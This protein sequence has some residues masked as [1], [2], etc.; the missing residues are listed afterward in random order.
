MQLTRLVDGRSLNSVGLSLGALR[1]SRHFPH[2]SP[3]SLG[4]L[5][6]LSAFV[7]AK[8]ARLPWLAK[9]A[10][11]QRVVGFGSTVRD[12]AEFVATDPHQKQN[13]GGMILTIADVDHVIMQLSKLGIDEVRLLPGMPADRADMALNGAI[14]VRELLRAAQVDKVQI[15]GASIREGL[16]LAHFQS[17]QGRE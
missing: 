5:E 16:A 4:Q 15:S 2:R 1:L 9:S 14:V 10:A 7:L 3:V 11:K 13:V 6:A 17:A 8:F 12:L